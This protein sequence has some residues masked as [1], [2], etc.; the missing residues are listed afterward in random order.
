MADI[1]ML[2]LAD[3]EWFREQFARF[4][5][6]QARTTVKGGALERVW[7]HPRRRS[8][9]ERRRD[10]SAEWWFGSGSGSRGQ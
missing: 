10:R 7:R 2:I 9:G 6:L 1:T 3:R 5:Y 8:R 4:D